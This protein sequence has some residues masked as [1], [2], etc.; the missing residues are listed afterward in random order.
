MYSK[1]KKRSSTKVHEMINYYMDNVAKLPA[2]N[3]EKFHRK[4]G[5]IVLKKNFKKYIKSKKNSKK[6]SNR[7]HSL[8]QLLNNVILDF[9]MQNKTKTTVEEFA[10]GK[11]R[12]PDESYRKPYKLMMDEALDELDDISINKNLFKKYIDLS[13]FW[14]KHL[15]NIVINK[16]INLKKIRVKIDYPIFYNFVSRPTLNF[17]H[18]NIGKLGP[19]LDPECKHRYFNTFIKIEELTE[20][21]KYWCQFLNKLVKKV[22]RTKISEGTIKSY[23]KMLKQ[24]NDTELDP[25]SKEISMHLLEFIYILKCVIV[26]PSNKGCL[27]LRLE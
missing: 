1:K 11:N 20:N 19:F 21:Q 13:D 7:Y 18:F 10:R 26:N 12:D 16:K 8:N 2:N 22:I 27:K 6:S 24:K 23:I 14:I 5:D 17:F 4:I 9:E 25:I 3:Q 15:D